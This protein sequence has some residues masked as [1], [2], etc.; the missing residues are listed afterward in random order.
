LHVADY[1]ARTAENCA[2]PRRAYNNSARIYEG[3]E[4]YISCHLNDGNRL[5]VVMMNIVIVY[6]TREGQTKKIAE[7]MA[8]WLR[9]RGDTADVIDADCATR[10]VE[11]ERFDGVL[12]VAPIHAGGYPRSIV[13]FAKNH[14]D[15]LERVPSAFCSVGLAIAS[16]TNDGRAQTLPLVEKFVKQTG[17]QPK[18][19]ELVAGALPYSKYNL[20]IRFIMRRIAAHEGGEV[21]TSRDYEYT[22]WGALDRFTS[23][24][25][26]E[27]M[28]SS[29]S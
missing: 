13:R 10:S 3:F 7:H 26:V 17:W 12:V 27:V 18:R 1:S 9:S 28:D 25:A 21:D 15:A 14:R 4:G 6:A 23:A 20:L 2:R 19:V 5:G 8:T 29:P 11:L 16:R 22:D 24:F